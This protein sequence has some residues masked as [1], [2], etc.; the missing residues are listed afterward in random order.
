[1]FAALET[2]A[3]RPAGRPA[4]TPAYD[5]AILR[6][7]LLRAVPRAD[8]AARLTHLFRRLARLDDEPPAS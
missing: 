1:M 6:A 4:G 5:L 7:V 3:A 8:E 2:P